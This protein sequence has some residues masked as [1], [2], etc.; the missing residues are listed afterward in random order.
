M[1]FKKILLLTVVFLNLSLIA[2]TDLPDAGV[3]KNWHFED[4]VLDWDD[5]SGANYYQ[6]KFYD[7]DGN[8]DVV[9]NR[10]AIRSYESFYDF[11]RFSNLYDLFFKI[12]VI[13]KDGSVR[14]S[15]MIQISIDRT[16]PRPKYVGGQ[17]LTQY[18]TW[19]NDGSER[20]DFLNYTLMINDEEHIVKSAEYDMTDYE[21]DIYEIIIIANYEEGSSLPS[22]PH[23]MFWQMETVSESIYFD[24]D[25]PEDLVFDLVDDAEVLAIKGTVG[26]FREYLP[27]KVAYVDDQQLIVTV[28]YII[29]EAKDTDIVMTIEVLTESYFYTIYLTRINLNP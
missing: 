10:S 3:I 9:S 27:E 16:Y 28:D 1:L 8:E 23:F 26:M 29:A 6:L 5:V 11:Y 19:D 18:L 7:E 15:D 12:E 17:Y 25:Q 21:P 22:K 2:C 14:V 20:D 13:D 24:F 4:D